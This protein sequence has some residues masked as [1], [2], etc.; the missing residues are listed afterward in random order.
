[1]KGTVVDSGA[2][3]QAPD[4]ASPNDTY[5][6]GG[7]PTGTFTAPMDWSATYLFRRPLNAAQRT[8]K[9]NFIRGR[10]GVVP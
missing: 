6:I 2:S 5:S 10:T 7:N 3:S 9:Q 8:V 4:T 1:V